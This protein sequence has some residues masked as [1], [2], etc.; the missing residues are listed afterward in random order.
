MTFYDKYDVYNAAKYSTFVG[1][2][3]LKLVNNIIET[4]IAWSEI[5]Y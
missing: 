5:L 2:E 1:K 3:A 4:P